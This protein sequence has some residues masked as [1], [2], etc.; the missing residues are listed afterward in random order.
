[1]KKTMVLAILFAAC[2][3]SLAAFE[4]KK[5]LDLPAQGLRELE[6]KAGAGSLTVAGREGLSA[7]QVEAEIVARHVGDDK[8]ES[9][10]R[11]RVE[12][13]LEKRGDAAVLVSR[14]REGGGLFRSDDAVINL[15][16]SVPKTLALDIDDGSGSM[17]VEDLA[18]ALRIEDGSGSIRVDRIGGAVTIDDGSG[19]IEISDVAGDLAIDDGSGEIRIRRVGGTVTIDDG[20]GG[21][22]IEDVEKNVRVIEA[23]SGGLAIA[24]VKGQVVRSR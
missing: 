23:G 20:S 2:A 10:L 14:I 1:M 7:I 19:G 12:L 3:G 4:T 22:D 17:V 13:T 21:I 18:A 9:Y 8:M 6:I 15:K 24:N 5:S 11:D 16:V